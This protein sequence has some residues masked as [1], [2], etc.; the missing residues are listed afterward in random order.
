MYYIIYTVLNTYSH[1]KSSSCRKFQIHSTDF[2]ECQ[3]DDTITC[4]NITEDC[5]N[6][7]QSYDCQC[8]DGYSENE[9]NICTSMQT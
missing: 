8:K 1:S 2:D 9:D 5:I 4:D 3:S 6:T 7:Y